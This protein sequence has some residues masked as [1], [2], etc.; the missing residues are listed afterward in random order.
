[1]KDKLW[2]DLHSTEEKIEFLRSGRAVDTGIMSKSIV[3]DILTA[4]ERIAK[5]EKS[6]AS[7]IGYDRCL[8]NE[9][10]VYEAVIGGNDN[11]L[12][13]RNV[14]D[15]AGSSELVDKGVETC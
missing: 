15:L 10:A 6:V 1:M 12:I 14:C 2:C 4:Y 9:E 11:H 3:Q 13:W 8:E 5:L 7:N